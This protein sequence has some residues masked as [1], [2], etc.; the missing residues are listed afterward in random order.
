MRVENEMLQGPPVDT[1]LRLGDPEI[2]LTLAAGVE[3]AESAANPRW[4]AADIQSASGQEAAQ[5]DG[6]RGGC[7]RNE[8]QNSGQR[9]RA[10]FHCITPAS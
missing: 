9:G 10:P 7:D 3:S 1:E 5:I 8:K 4:R 6:L 2:L